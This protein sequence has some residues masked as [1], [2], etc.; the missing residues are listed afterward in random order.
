MLLEIPPSTTLLDRPRARW[1]RHELPTDVL[2]PQ[3][4]S[5][6]AW[7]GRRLSD[8]KHRSA[9]GQAAYGAGI[10]SYH[11]QQLEPAVR[12]LATFFELRAAAEAEG[13]DFAL[14]PAGLPLARFY[15]GHACFNT[16]R[17]ARA[18][19][20]LYGGTARY[21]RATSRRAVRATLWAA[22]VTASATAT[23]HAIS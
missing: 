13:D 3:P 22:T 12:H 9:L 1:G 7:R 6:R 16:G 19:E 5:R 21:A 2:V 15:L 20:Q 10:A 14:P 23:S 11:M 18:K 17:Y 4:P 8:A